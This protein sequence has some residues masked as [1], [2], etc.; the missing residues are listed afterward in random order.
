MPNIDSTRPLLNDKVAGAEGAYPAGGAT[1]DG[2]RVPLK[3]EYT[4]EEL[5]YERGSR[6][7]PKQV[8]LTDDRIEASVLRRLGLDVKDPA[9]YKLIQQRLKTSGS[10]FAQ[11]ETTGSNV[12][13]YNA[14]TGRYE[15]NIGVERALYK[16]LKGAATEAQAQLETERRRET[17]ANTSPSDTVAGNRNIDSAAAER[18]KLLRLLEDAQV[19][20]STF[21]T[22]SSLRDLKRVSVQIPDDGK[23]VTADRALLNYIQQR[24]GGGNLWGPDIRDI[25]EL[26]KQR[27]VR[28]E[29]LQVQA[30]AGGGRTAQ[31][32]ISVENL[33]KLH[34]TYLGVQEKVNA[35]IA[36]FDKVKEANELNRF[37]RGVFN[38]AWGS[39]KASWDTITDPIG[40]LNNIREAV[41]TLLTLSPSDIAKI[42]SN[43]ASDGVEWAK[44]ATPGEIA[45]KA[46]EIIGA[47][48][49]EIILGK[50]AGVALR[51][52][53]G[54]KAI[55]S[56]VNKTKDAADAFK[57]A[58][59]NIPIPTPG[60]RVVTDTM[61]NRY[62]FPNLEL[63]KLDDLIRPMERRGDDL[64]VNDRRNVGSHEV[65]GGHTL[66]KHVGKSETWLR[67]RLQN[68]PDIGDYASSF[69]NEAIANR[70]QGRFVNRF[71]ADIDNWLKDG[72]NRR[73]VVQFDMGEAV[74]IVVERG[75]SG[76]V[77]TS[78]VAV[79]L[80]KDSSPQGWHFLT[81]FPTK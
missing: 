79:V 77:T 48:I 24:Y 55:T 5:G 20:P 13:T 42:A 51:A 12:A 65:L 26:A 66:E 11:L 7:L 50:G 41:G 74:G 37:V 35:D 62:V 38:G 15:L 76:A 60:V 1:A 10:P 53:R 34:H 33:L 25:F 14:K 22:P 17:Q 70:A 4:P 47:A 30:G 45:E 59:G 28:A 71:K 8:T 3:L 9:D 18:G 2:G 67:Q 63:N 29:N 58:A 73:L 54:T 61:G 81:S 46:G 32:D 40:T 23:E 36:I 57:Q 44:N 72:S 68:D 21:G 75:K 52:L 27:G 78:K 31:F 16:K 19:I 6:N 56:L 69:R 43:L 49:V 64:G 39:L 80:V